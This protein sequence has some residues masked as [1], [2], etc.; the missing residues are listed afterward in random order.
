MWP[1]KKKP[2]L[3][4]E[5]ALWHVT[6]MCW[7]ISNLYHTPMFQDTR[8]ILPSAG[9]FTSKKKG[10][11]LA[12]DILEQ[13]KLYAVMKEW[14]VTLESDKKTY[15]TSKYE[16]IQAPSE[17]TPLGMFINHHA[18]GALIVYN[19]DLLNDPMS[20]VATM[21]HELSHYLIHSIHAPLPCEEEE[22]EFLT[23]QTACFLGFG[24]FMA[25]NVFDFEQWR[26]EATG[27]QGWQSKRRGYLP[28]ADMIFNLA[29]FLEVK[30]IDPEKALAS[31]KP[32]LAKQLK[33]A[34]KD[35]PRWKDRLTNAIDAARA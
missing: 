33:L 18:N 16:L 26:D 34:L 23:D 15:A 2:F 17:H 21:A 7:L 19:P 20:L 30:T 5:T 32:H 27:V 22:E 11:D 8:L 35:M 1:F 29:L 25:N 13:V 24:V 10:H 14:H 9:F 6:N 4:E 12:V 3:D 31:L 28:E